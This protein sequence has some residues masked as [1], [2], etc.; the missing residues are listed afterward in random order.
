MDRAVAAWA[1]RNK[2]TLIALGCGVA[3]GVATA[4]TTAAQAAW[5][6][7]AAIQATSAITAFSGGSSTGQKLAADAGLFC[8]IIGDVAASGRARS[9]GNWC[10]A[11][12]DSF[13][14]TAVLIDL[15]RSIDRARRHVL[16][17]P[18]LDPDSSKRG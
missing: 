16:Q 10:G 7:L 8:F 12:L 18:Y 11:V 17:N 4:G 3:A 14:G 1:W 2:E 13:A 5:A 9:A 15:D 6:C